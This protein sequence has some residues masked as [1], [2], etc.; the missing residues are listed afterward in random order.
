MSKADVR[1]LCEMCR[2]DYPNVN[3]IIALVKNKPFIAKSNDWY[4]MA[5]VQ[6]LAM[7][8]KID[9]ATFSIILAEAPKLKADY[10]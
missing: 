4:G 3:A 5:P 2:S 7:N 6:Y 9:A 10:E 1:I 8:K